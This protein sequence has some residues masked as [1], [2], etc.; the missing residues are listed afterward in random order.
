MANSNPTQPQKMF[1]NQVRATEL[2]SGGVLGTALYSF[3]RRDGHIDTFNRTE[4][5]VYK[6]Q[7]GERERMK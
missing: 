7:V 1:Q 5:A 4:L 3:W 2:L 6:L